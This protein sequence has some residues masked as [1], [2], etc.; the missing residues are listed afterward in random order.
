[1]TADDL[2]NYLNSPEQLM[3]ISIEEL[4]KWA[5]K[6]PYSQHLK[7][8]LWRKAR[9][10][11]HPLEKTYEQSCAAYTYDRQHL[12]D[13]IQNFPNSKEPEVATII[14]EKEVIEIDSKEA[15]ATPLTKISN[16]PKTSVEA[17]TENPVV[18]DSENLIEEGMRFDNMIEDRQIT[19]S[20]DVVKFVDKF[21]SLEKEIVPNKSNI[22]H[23]L[24]QIWEKKI[25]QDTF[26]QHE[27]TPKT[28]FSSWLN[29]LKAPK[30]VAQKMD[31]FIVP[32]TATKSEAINKQ[33]KAKPKASKPKKDTEK[34]GA[35]KSLEKS[36]D[37]FSEHLAE[38]LAKQG[39]NKRAIQMFEKLILAFPEKSTY[40]AE[41]IEKLKI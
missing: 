34:S 17:S 9:Q 22:E 35:E 19:L 41:K 5:N 39:H 32:N 27:P 12:F 20:S 37:I 36:E 18:K 23:N 30:V 7:Y 24:E 10:T 28:A 21:M 11:D 16:Y 3:N 13:L 6:Y 40:F 4:T 38:L 29:T 15:I 14:V 1:M 33:E 25:H 8:L 26:I 2:S 31:D